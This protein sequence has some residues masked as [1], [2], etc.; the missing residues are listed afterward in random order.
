[1]TMLREDEFNEFKKTTG[2]LNEAMIS[3]SAML[4]KHKHGKIFFGLKNNGEPFPFTINDSSLRDVS[5][6][7]FEAIRPQLIPVIRVETVTGTE[8]IVMEFSGED[9]PYSAFGRYY[10]RT[11]DEDRELTPSE[12][13]KIMIFREYT[14]NWENKSTVQTT[15]DADDKTVRTFFEMAVSCGRIPK[16]DYD[17]QAVLNQI[18]VL[19]GKNLTNAG[20]ML[21]SDKK[22]LILKSGVFATEH[23]ETL[24]DIA[25]NAG[26]IF[27]LITA[28]SSYIIRNIRWRAELSTD[29]IH[30][31]EIP[32]VPIDAL[33][34]AIINS[35]AHARYDIPVQHEIDIFSNRI[36]ICN[37]GNFA[38]EH[39]PID[40][41]NRDL[42]SYLRNEVIARVLYL[43]KEVE[44]F[45]TGLKKIYSLC[46]AAGISVSYMNEENSFTIEFSRNDR[47]KDPSAP[48]KNDIADKNII[49]SGEFKLTNL[50][51]DNPRLT[52]QEL[53][54]SS[55]LSERTVSRILANLKR[56]GLIKREGSNRTGYWKVL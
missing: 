44:T 5:R 52:N 6:K 8:V 39:E 34:E 37:P 45:G 15:D 51:K 16:M 32:E 10:V 30:R 40:F 35:F 2:E 56:K 33:R 46:A 48:N 55:G 11:A 54:A 9:V 26:N 22:P 18:G 14:D 50:L 38:S 43:C 41:A 3:V 12:L 1:M 53:A 7:V 4:N 28:A 24:L 17:K 19:N 21:F 29:G 27:Q 23:K 36:S 13:R 25:E 49:N 20:V 47:N 42:R 31:K